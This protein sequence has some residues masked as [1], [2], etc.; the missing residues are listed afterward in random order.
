MFSSFISESSAASGGVREAFQNGHLILLALA[1]IAACGFEF[2][3]GF[4]DT[5]NAVA[6]VIYT[7]SLKPWA[8]VTLSGICNFLGVI[9]GGTA[10]AMGIIKLL[11]VELLVTHNLGVSL[12][13]VFALL[14][15]AVIWN[16]GTW[17]LGLPA[18][19]S[20]T[21]IGSILGI[22][23]ANAYLSGA[24]L[25]SGVNWGKAYDIGLALL[26]SPVIGFTMSGL[27]LA[28]SRKLLNHPEFQK[29]PTADQ[30][31]PWKI[32]ALLTATSSGVSFAH[33]SNDGQKGI[34]L[35][36]LVL[37]AI[38]PS[39]FALRPTATSEEIHQAIA[40]TQRVEQLVA[41]NGQSG[42]SDRILLA[43]AAPSNVEL[44]T[45]DRFELRASIL[46]MDQKLAKIEKSGGPLVRSA[47]WS[48]IQK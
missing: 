9:L 48:E 31:P 42:N 12:A 15:G 21:L 27:L 38:A 34:G 14:A 6:T 7:R 20:H 24:P 26:I 13:M 40:S 3:N 28:V 11:P 39:Q 5:A 4:H 33:G 22:G 46:K 44:T 32:R 1:L 41:Q 30:T 19:S 23:L 45:Q 47:G 43:Q 8:A 2:I 37:I 18:S 10:V 17:Y 29:A 35:I 25:A 16:L 36:M